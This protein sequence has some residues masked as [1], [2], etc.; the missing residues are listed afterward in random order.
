MSTREVT[1]LVTS[2]SLGP[3]LPAVVAFGGG[4]GLAASLTALRRVTDHLTAIVTVADDGGSSGRLRKQFGM[5]PPGDFRNCLVALA[6][7]APIMGRLFQHRFGG[8]G[9]LSGHA[10]GNL[11]LAAL[12]QWGL[13]LPRLIAG[14]AGAGAGDVVAVTY[15]YGNTFLMAAGLLNALVALDVFDRARGLKGR[16]AA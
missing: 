16:L 2:G 6:D 13:V 9:E 8:K 12:A 10:F 11:F 7:E 5:L 1:R 3:T 15:E 4:H 14:V